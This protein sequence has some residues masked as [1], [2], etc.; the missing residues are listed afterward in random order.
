MM[1]MIPVDFQVIGGSVLMT[2][3]GLGRTMLW[4]MSAMTGLKLL[5]LPTI[6][7]SAL[8]VC[9]CVSSI[10]RIDPSVMARGDAG[11]YCATAWNI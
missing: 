7:S 4:V 10:T 2:G 1:T 8:C 3:P 5:K 6:G 9:V 11:E